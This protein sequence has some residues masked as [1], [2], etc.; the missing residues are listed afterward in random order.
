MTGALPGLLRLLWATIERPAEVAR[1]ILAQRLS[2]QTLWLA[3][4]LVTVLSVLLVG[5]LN[6]VAPPPEDAVM[7]AVTPF[8]YAFIL[9]GSLVIA[10]FALHFTGRMLGG[11]GELPDTLALLVWLQTL[12]LALQLVQLVLILVSP[13]LGG[14]AALLSIA[15]ALWV[16]LHFINEA[17]SF[18][19]LGRA[20]L[21]LVVSLL[22]M[23]VGLSVLLGLIGAIAGTGDI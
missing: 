6:L 21:T 8:A 7:L 20:A 5:L 1:M 23:G 13:L 19:S 22:G 10:V 2:R 12:L 9:G 14:I 15:A 4:V 11:S 3:L 16:L 17:Q 18:G